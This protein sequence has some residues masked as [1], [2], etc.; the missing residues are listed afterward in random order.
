MKKIILMSSLT[1]LTLGAGAAFAFNSGEK[2]VVNNEKVY[3]EEDVVDFYTSGAEED[4][5]K[6]V[7]AIEGVS[8]SGISSSE[9]KTVVPIDGMTEDEYKEAI[10]SF[11]KM[12]NLEDVKREIVQM[13]QQKIESKELRRLMGGD[14]PI[15]PFTPAYPSGLGWFESIPD[16]AI[17]TDNNLEYLNFFV[18]GLA[19]DEETTE[20]YQGFLTDWQNGDYN[21]LIEIHKDLLND[22]AI[23]SDIRDAYLAADDLQ[24]ATKEQEE[25]YLEHFFSEDDDYIQTET[26][27]GDLF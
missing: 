10:H 8:S 11:G 6:E 9:E 21:E 2:E 3:A 20:Y 13:T 14:A 23:E 27:F 16:Y 24:L 7:P 17:M 19:V 26:E 18:E 15:F 4:P 12:V 1:V 22:V 25:A 5:N